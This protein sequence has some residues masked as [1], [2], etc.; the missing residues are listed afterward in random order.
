M[1]LFAIKVQEQRQILIKQLKYLERKES[2]LKFEAHEK[3]FWKADREQQAMRKAR[4]QDKLTKEQKEAIERKRKMEKSYE[5]DI[6]LAARY[7]NRPGFWI[8]P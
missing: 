5:M 6:S 2:D 3:A 4:L 7:G 1:K 8:D